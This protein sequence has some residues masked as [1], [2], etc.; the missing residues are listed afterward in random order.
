LLSISGEKA[1]FHKINFYLILASVIEESFVHLHNSFPSHHDRFSRIS[2]QWRET[3]EGT[4]NNS[5][6]RQEEQKLLQ[7]KFPELRN[8]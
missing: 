4:L 3:L 1:V 5:H 8:C 7:K 6:V 2:K